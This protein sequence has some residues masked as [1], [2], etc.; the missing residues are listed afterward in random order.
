VNHDTEGSFDSVDA[1]GQLLSTRFGSWRGAA[2]DIKVEGNDLYVSSNSN[3][4]GRWNATTGARTLVTYCGGDGQAVAHLGDHVYG[5]FHESCTDEAGADDFSLRLVDVNARTGRRDYDF[6]P[7][8][9]Q[10]WGV[11]DIVGDNTVMVIAGQFRSISGV[12]VSGFAIF[13]AV[14]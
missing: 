9:D 7:S 11:R 12:T 3:R 8:F 10:F 4:V 1:T 2:L 14:A 5:G 6:A 13:D